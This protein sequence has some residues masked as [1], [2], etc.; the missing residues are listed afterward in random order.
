MLISFTAL[1]TVMVITFLL[2][3]LTSFIM[4]INA[5]ARAKE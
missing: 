2:G 4:I 5:I 1:L 3:M